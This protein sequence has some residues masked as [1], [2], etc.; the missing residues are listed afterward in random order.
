MGLCSNVSGIV[1]KTFLFLQSYDYCNPFE[2]TTITLSF[3]KC[4]INVNFLRILD[5]T[6]RFSIASLQL[7]SCGLAARTMELTNMRNNFK[8]S[9]NFSCFL[10]DLWL[11]SA[12]MMQESLGILT[13]HLDQQ[14]RRRER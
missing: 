8:F 11:R 5:K 9:C 1:H 13:Y 2:F 3:F 6:T 10:L 12:D 4:H 14:R 7:T